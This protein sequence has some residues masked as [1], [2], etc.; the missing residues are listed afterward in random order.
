[1]IAAEGIGC[2]LEMGTQYVTDCECDVLL[3]ARMPYLSG[4]SL[5]EGIPAPASLKDGESGLV[6][7]EQVDELVREL[8]SPQL[9]G[10]CGVESLE[11]ADEGIVSKYP[12]CE[13]GMIGSSCCD[14]STTGHAGVDVQVYQ[15]PVVLVDEEHAI[16]GGD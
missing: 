1:M 14:G 11:M 9:D 10:Q 12:G 3:H 4:A 5:E 8:R 13:D 15:M 2:F 7:G 16:G 6:V